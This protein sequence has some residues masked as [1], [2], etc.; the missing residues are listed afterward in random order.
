MPTITAL[1]LYPI[2]SCAGIALQAATVTA[3][4]L[5]HQQAHDREWMVVDSGG[6]FLSQRSHPA[7]ALIVPVLQ[8]GTMTVQAPGMPPLLVPTAPL[9]RAQ[10]ASL[11]VVVWDDHLNA[12]DC[13]DAAAAW[14]S[15]VL[16]QPCKLVRFDP[17]ARRLASKKWTLDADAPTRFADGYPML[18]ISQGS[19]DD[20]NRKLQA[21]D[22]TPLPMNRFRPNIVIDGVDAFEEDFLE[23]LQAG[24]VCLQPV[25]PCTRC[26]MPAID[27]ASGEIG[28][29][30][31]DILL[32]YRAN[33]RVDG[34]VTFGVNM[35]V[36][37]GN[38]A[39]LRIGQDIEGELAF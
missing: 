34:A 30:P 24:P 21:Q 4:G 14:F 3:S 38:G 13:G 7:M 9:D 37:E 10:A 6:Q 18:L 35:I 36:R 27:Q 32:T 25:K 17:G 39:I 29:D 2:K 8:A 26:P 31:M 33:P 15:R 28:P 19:L 23:T 1:T 16:G 22:R 11:A 12:H 20:L 5:S